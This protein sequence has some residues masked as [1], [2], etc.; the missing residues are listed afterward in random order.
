METDA[1]QNAGSGNFVVQMGMLEPCL[2]NKK[3][4]ECGE[5]PLGIL[6]VLFSS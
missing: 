3:I 2:G 1:Y 4:M 6:G 5:V